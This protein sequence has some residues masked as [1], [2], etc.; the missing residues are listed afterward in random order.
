MIQKISA[1]RTE[2]I[3]S[4]HFAGPSGGIAYVGGKWGGVGG[5]TT[6]SGTTATRLAELLPP[7]RQPTKDKPT[8]AMGTIIML[9]GLALMPVLCISAGNES[10]QWLAFIIG[11]GVFVAGLFIAQK[12]AA[13]A[14]PALDAKYA[15]D[16][17]A[18]QQQ[19][20]LYERIYY[21]HRDGISFDP[22]TGQHRPL[23]ETWKLIFGDPSPVQTS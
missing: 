19:V 13:A 14:K 2:G 23:M 18:W 11:G 3:S 6:L 17:A 1:I 16:L 8:A 5:Y 4:G 15:R 20:Q 9:V 7:P 12:S 10:G 21:C 22:E